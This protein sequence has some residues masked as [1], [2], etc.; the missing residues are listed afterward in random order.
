LGMVLY[1]E[2]QE[3]VFLGRDMMRFKEYRE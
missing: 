2:S 3:Y 1:G